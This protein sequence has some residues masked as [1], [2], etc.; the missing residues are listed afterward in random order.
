MGAC[1]R[2]SFV[3]SQFGNNYAQNSGGDTQTPPPELAAG[4]QVGR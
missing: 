3:Q 1:F 4:S 2:R